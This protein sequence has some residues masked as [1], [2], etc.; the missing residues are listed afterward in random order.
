MIEV[1]VDESVRIDRDFVLSSR[2][3]EVQIRQT[4]GD[5]LYEQPEVAPQLGQAWQEPARC[6]MS[7]HT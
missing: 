6:M 2:K 3:A 1:G 7:P 5:S 4:Q